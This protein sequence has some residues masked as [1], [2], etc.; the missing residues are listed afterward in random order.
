MNCIH[1]VRIEIKI[2]DNMKKPQIK[3]KIKN[4][5]MTINI[6]DHA[7]NKVANQL[8]T[9]SLIIKDLFLD[10]VDSREEELLS[11]LPEHIY[12]KIF[13]EKYPDIY[14]KYGE[15]DKVAHMLELYKLKLSD[16]LKL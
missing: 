8:N 16:L 9:L 4:N 15:R 13:L 5:R 2:I 1:D 10:I 6:E 3:S 7:S 14:S 11:M 12:E